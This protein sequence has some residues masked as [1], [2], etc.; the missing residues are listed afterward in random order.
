M[1]LISLVLTTEQCMSRKKD[2]IKDIFYEIIT[3]KKIKNFEKLKMGQIS[4]WDSLSNLNFLLKI[5]EK[6]KVKFSIDDMSKI[7]SIKAV[8]NF[9]KRRNK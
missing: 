3:T 6:L 4:A 7:N 1:T 9:L 8:R 2:K 5:E